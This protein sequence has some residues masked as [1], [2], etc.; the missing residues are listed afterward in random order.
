VSELDAVPFGTGQECHG[1]TVG[2][3]DLREVESDDTA[4]FQRVVKDIQVFPCD[5]AADAKND[6]LL[7]RKSVDSAR[8]GLC[9][10]L[11]GWLNG[12]A[13]ASRNP[14]KMQ[15]NARC[16]VDDDWWIWLIRLIWWIGLIRVNPAIL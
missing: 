1:I 9:R 10:L 5:P 15:Q 3:F 4:F 11:P 7:T 13:N 14:L 6:T 8:H 16:R 12:K 2:Q